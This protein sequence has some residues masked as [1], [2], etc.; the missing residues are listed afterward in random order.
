MPVAR[1]SFELR[2]G[3]FRELVFL[4]GADR[5]CQ[6]P[7]A[8]VRFAGLK[9]E[10]SE[11]LRRRRAVSQ[12]LPMAAPLD[13]SLTDGPAADPDDVILRRPFLSSHKTLNL[14]L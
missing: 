2:L 8:K 13:W 6:G 3:A 7:R 5:I 4:A 10:R 14:P 11:F 9:Q 12:G 1:S